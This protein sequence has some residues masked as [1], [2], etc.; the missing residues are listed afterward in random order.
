[1]IVL[2]MSSKWG[3]FSTA[4][5]DVG[6]GTSAVATTACLKALEGKEWHG[7]QLSGFRGRDGFDPSLDGFD[8]ARAD[9]V[10]LGDHAWTGCVQDRIHAPSD[11]V[12]GARQ[13]SGGEV[14]RDRMGV[15]RSGL[16]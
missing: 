15:P 1:M 16:S 5:L 14:D 10:A 7:Q 6:T 11:G 3:Q 4:I 13:K 9:G 12:F 8:R 2:S